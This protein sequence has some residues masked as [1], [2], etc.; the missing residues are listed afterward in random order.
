MTVETART[1]L[2]HSTAFSKAQAKNQDAP[3]VVPVKCKT[4][5]H[6]SVRNEGK[7]RSS[8]SVAACLLPPSKKQVDPLFAAPPGIHRALVHL[9]V[10]LDNRVLRHAAGLDLAVDDAHAKTNIEYA[11]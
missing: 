7:W 4:C 2:R 11:T 10:R 8:D 5:A 3:H 9:R 1:T 6:C